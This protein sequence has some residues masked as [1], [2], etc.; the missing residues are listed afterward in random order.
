MTNAIDDWVNAQ[1]TLNGFYC[2]DEQLL[3]RIKAE[4][5]KLS[6]REREILKLRYGLGDGYIYTLE[7]VGHIFKVTRERIRG[8]VKKAIDKLAK[9]DGMDGVHDALARRLKQPNKDEP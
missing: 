7:E 6:Y 2:D 4:L 3:G 5:S 1:T 8:I 9:Q